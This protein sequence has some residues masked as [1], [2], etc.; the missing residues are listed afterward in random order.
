MRDSTNQ[1]KDRQQTATS[2]AHFREEKTETSQKRNKQEHKKMAVNET[3]HRLS[4][5]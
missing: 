4:N 3:K 1:Q 2:E 5:R